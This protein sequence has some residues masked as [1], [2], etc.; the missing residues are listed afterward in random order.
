MTADPRE[1][2]AEDGTIRTGAARHRVP[3][4]YEPALA[5][6]LAAVPEDVSVYLYG[7]V[8]TGRAR[9]PDSDVDLV[10]L[11]MD[12]A[13][14]AGLATSLSRRHAGLCREVAIAPGTVRGHVGPGDEAHGNR[15]FLRHHCVHLAGPDP[16]ADIAPVLADA[17]AARGFNGDIAV[18]LQRWRSA[19]DRLVEDLTGAGPD[20]RATAVARLATRV[21]RK[22]LVTVA[23]LVSVHDGTWTTARREAARRWAR[24][25]PAAAPG[26]ATLVA[27][28]DAPSEDLDEV[29]R[30]LDEVVA[31]L[32]ERFAADVGPWRP[33]SVPGEAGAPVT[34]P[35]DDAG[36]DVAPGSDDPSDASID[37]GGDGAG[38]DA[39]GD[40]RLWGARIASGPAPAAWALGVSTHVD[41]R[42]AQEDLDGSLAHA[43]ELHRIGILDPG[44]HGQMV[45]ALQRA[46]RL[47]AEDSFPLRDDDEDVHGAIERWLVEELGP[48]GGKLRAGRSRNDQIA[49]DL[50]LYLRRRTAD[51]VAGIRDVQTAL[52]DVADAHLGWL[53]PGMTHLQRGQP[54]LLSHALLSWVWMLERDVGRLGDFA[55]RVDESVLGAGAM[56]GTTLPIDPARTAAD[57]GFA[58]VAANSMDAVASRDLAAEFLAACAI[59]GVTCSRLGEELVLWASAEFG[60]GR[61]GDA[62]TTGSSIMPQKRNPDTAELVR[63]KSARLIGDLT[64]VLTLTK[65]LPLTYNRDLQEDKEPVFDAVDT[66]MLVLPALAGTVAGLQLDRDRLEEAAAGGFSLATD[67]AEE[68]A[69]RGVPFRDAHEVA[70][71]LV[72]VAEDRGGDLD[73]LTADDLAAAHAALATDTDEV[74]ALLDVRSAVERR[75]SSLG[76]ATASVRAQLA[77]ARAAIAGHPADTPPDTAPA[78]ARD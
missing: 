57:L 19:R 53:A 65:G 11:G 46:K 38:H 59:L 1:G 36:V 60:F 13:D 5:D 30:V 78:D 69:R 45:A 26:L 28:L 44:E 63:G 14:A 61:P 64:A 31:P 39:T 32:A 70:G 29:G 71:R 12:P 34:H 54:V 49:G 56:A 68:L 21:S 20:V 75:D 22:S 8:A 6:V 33:V 37:D 27:W 2:I 3:A 35:E 66:L 73:V 62:W 77:A 23:G 48:L 4:V 42:L 52:C 40:G 50:R 25:D 16:A 51:V 15:A 55:V 24:L 74:V 17:R 43:G 10:V 47:F 41:V 18:H 67:L 72:R 7:S 76:T 9:P 58:R